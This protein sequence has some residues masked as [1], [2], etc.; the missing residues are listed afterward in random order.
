MKEKDNLSLKQPQCAEVQTAETEKEE[1]KRPEQTPASPTDEGVSPEGEL[2]QRLQPSVNKQCLSEGLTS[3]GEINT[4]VQNVS[5]NPERFTYYSA[6]LGSTGFSLGRHWWVVEVGDHPDWTIGVVTES[7]ER[8]PRCRALP[9]QGFWCLTYRDNK[10]TD[11]SGKTLK[12]SRRLEKFC[13]VLHCD[14][15]KGRVSFYD[16]KDWTLLCSHR[17]AFTEKVFP[18]F[19]VGEAQGTNVTKDIYVYVPD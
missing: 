15:F 16:T 14:D 4:P 2:C 1:R 12:L 18:Y 13:V 19:S 3:V 6:A 10:Y 7:A 11:I 17:Q 8:G 9:E 5:P